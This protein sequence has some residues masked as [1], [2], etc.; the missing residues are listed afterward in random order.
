MALFLRQ[1]ALLLRPMGLFW[2]GPQRTKTTTTSMAFERSEMI[3]YKGNEHM[4]GGRPEGQFKKTIKM[5]KNENEADADFD[6]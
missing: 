2:E 5:K 1:M 4:W 6:P 3:G